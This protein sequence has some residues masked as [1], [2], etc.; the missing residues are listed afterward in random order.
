M[1]KILRKDFTMNKKI[2]GLET[3]F[4]ILMFSINAIILNTPQIIIKQSASGSFSNTI[5]IGIIA[6]IFLI[7][8]N[9][10]LAYFPNFDI[11]DIS[12]FL[13]GKI[14]KLIIG[15]LFIIIFILIICTYIGQFIMLLKTVY[16]QNSPEL[17]I[18][19]PFIFCILFSN[20]NGFGSIKNLVCFFL[21]ISLLTLCLIFANNFS[22]ISLIKITP[23]FGNSIKETLI[24]GSSNIFVFTNIILIY[25]LQPFLK[26]TKNFKK[27]NI[28]GFTISWLFLILSVIVLL[29]TH[30]INNS[31][32]D[33]NPLYS[34]TRRIKLSQFI[35]RADGLFV[36]IAL[37]ACFS[38]LSF[39]TYLISIIIKK[40]FIFES[41]KTLTYSIIPYITCITYFL[42]KTNLY[43]KSDIYGDIFNFTIY[44][45]SI[46]IL[47]FAVIKKK[48]I[49]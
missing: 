7:I 5:Y 1:E 43:I 8:A 10:L 11:L 13:G 27:I 25:F 45:T 39:L 35:E 41:E 42:I 38:Y 4:I 28:I 33:L 22:N 30:P 31:I 29:S 23:I 14:L 37:L 17:F 47:F 6:F 9:K 36:T 44:Y 16:F 15:L 26:S 40:I 2:S 19:L 12:N 21:P 24:D 20:L 46:I 49:S 18:L 34:Q 32:F 3:F 48:L